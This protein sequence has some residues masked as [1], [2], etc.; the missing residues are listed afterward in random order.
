LE[1]RIWP[2][3][4]MRAVHLWAANELLYGE[5]PSLLSSP[6]C[7]IEQEILDKGSLMAWS[8]LGCTL[9]F[10]AAN[11]LLLFPH[12]LFV[13]FAMGLA[14]V[15]FLLGLGGLIDPRICVFGDAPSSNSPGWPRVTRNA[16][17]AV[18]GLAGAGLVLY[19]M[20]S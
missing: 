7:R 17:I 5:G 20:T 10:V 11:L 3:I 16:L 18:G 15:C 2:W 9:V 6:S 19:H 4:S 8:F 13:P 1:V 12:R 14:P